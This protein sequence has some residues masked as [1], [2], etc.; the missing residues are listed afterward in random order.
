M[1]G[2]QRLRRCSLHV[3]QEFD[4]LPVMMPVGMLYPLYKKRDLRQER[5]RQLGLQF[6]E[7]I[8]VLASYLGA[9]YSL[10]NGL[11]MCTGELE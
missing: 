1:H 4:S 10:E 5:I 6:K 3:L 9:G 11:A 8:L 2:N 7:G